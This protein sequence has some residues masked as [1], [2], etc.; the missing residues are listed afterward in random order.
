MKTN[1]LWFTIGALTL[2]IIVIIYFN[3]YATKP[4]DSG[5]VAMHECNTHHLEARIAS[6]EDQ[7]RNL[8][9]ICQQQSTKVE[10][11]P[12]PAP[13]R[14]IE[15]KTSP[16]PIPVPAKAI[17]SDFS[18]IQ[19]ANGD[20]I[21]CVMAN[22]DEGMHFPQYAINRNVSFTSTVSNTTRDGTN[23][24]VV[25]TESMQDDYGI[26]HDGTFYVRHEIIQKTLTETLANLAIK[27][28]FT[29]WQPLPMT[30][31]NGYWIYKTR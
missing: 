16:Q 29:K 14:T 5:R 1:Q 9:I 18:H 20:I 11:V 10:V 13:K 3:F 21:F 8:Q 6:L 25:P 17:V 7:V 15:V 31:E 2:I 19:N 23:W 4:G 26:T 24:L 28:E 30:K 27:S 22:K 12:H